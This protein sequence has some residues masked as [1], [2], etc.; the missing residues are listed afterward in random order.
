MFSSPSFANMTSRLY[1]V[2]GLALSTLTVSIST[3]TAQTDAVGAAEDSKVRTQWMQG[4]VKI[5]EAQKADRANDLPSALEL[6][7]QAH[8]VLVDVHKK[9]PDWNPS[10]LRFRIA[11]CEEQ[12]Q[13]LEMSADSD[14]ANMTRE[15]LIFM[16]RENTEEIRSLLKENESLKDELQTVRPALDEA[17]KNAKRNEGSAEQTEEL[18]RENR[19]LL[20]KVEVQ[21]ERLDRLSA[22]LTS[23]KETSGIQQAEQE[24]RTELDVAVARRTELENLLNNMRD[25]YDQLE[26]RLRDAALSRQQEQTRVKELQQ[27]LQNQQDALAQREQRI[28][29]LEDQLKQARLSIPELE[30]RLEQLGQTVENQR[31]VKEML[32]KEL[33]S[34]REI[35]D[36]YSEVVRE[37]NALQI[38]LTEAENRPSGPGTDG[39]IDIN[40]ADDIPAP[41]KPPPLDQISDKVIEKTGHEL[42]ERHGQR[43]GG[44]DKLTMRRHVLYL[45]QDIVQLRLEKNYRDRLLERDRKILEALKN[46]VDALTAQNATLSAKL[47]ALDEQKTITAQVDALLTQKDRQIRILQEKIDLFEKT[48]GENTEKLLTA[49]ATLEELKKENTE[50]RTMLANIQSAREQLAEKTAELQAIKNPN[51]TTKELQSKLEEMN[52]TNARLIQEQA[53]LKSRIDDQV[54]LLRL[55]ER[56]LA[57]LGQENKNLEE[58]V[59]AQAKNLQNQAENL[60]DWNTTTSV[61]MEARAELID[62]ESSLYEI[63]E[64]LQH[65]ISDR[66]EARQRAE[67]L[68][69]QLADREKSLA[70]LR[71][72]LEEERNSDSAAVNNAL[73][74]QLMNKTR[75]L[76]LERQRLQAIKDALAKA[77]ESKLPEIQDISLTAEQQQ[78]RKTREQFVR[79][80]LREALAA[81]KADDPEAAVWNYQKVLEYDAQNKLALQRLG[82]L[83]I[84]AERDEDAE[85]YLRRAFYIDPDDRNTLLPLGFVYARQKKTD[86]AISTLTRAVALAPADAEVHRQLGIACVNLGWQDAAE[87]EFRRALEIDNTDGAAAFNLAILLAADEPPRLSEARKW[88]YKARSLGTKGDSELD[89]FFKYSQS[90]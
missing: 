31:D 25:D 54:H 35:R 55:Q 68:E 49:T 22:E 47:E 1:I 26:N 52:Q 41:P 45:Y 61:D 37:K 75:E 50:L 16:V 88:Y 34:L 33:V 32:T 10:L 11:Y 85:R 19:Q 39:L 84:Q 77:S 58:A 8:A 23:L 28:Q 78:R 51:Q 13:R 60:T 71:N 46:K 3:T 7:R 66:E 18:L 29:Q 79:N 72:T 12:I 38:K 14:Y 74:V 2:I 17:K 62:A 83:S 82:Q 67:K 89:A 48:R 81:E 90:N 86:L 30:A 70:E 21:K 65:A 9:H 80:L 36:H 40:S 56:S 15:D 44:A 64:R 59:K 24:L 57:R 87:H 27:E 63:A 76:E 4:Y 5:E 20:T 53:N 42:T 69:D 73:L 6:Y 43:V